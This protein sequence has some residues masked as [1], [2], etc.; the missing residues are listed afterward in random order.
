[1]E[2]VSSSDCSLAILDGEGISVSSLIC[3][4]TESLLSLGLNSGLGS[5][6]ALLACDCV[7]ISLMKLVDSSR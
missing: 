4:I 7:M 6:V 5:G 1:L 3:C 2:L